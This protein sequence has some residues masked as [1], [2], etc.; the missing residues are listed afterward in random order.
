MSVIDPETNQSNDDQ[1]VIN[2]KGIEDELAQV[3]LFHTLLA[4]DSQ[5]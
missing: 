3:Q 1:V 5:G 4:T 2:A